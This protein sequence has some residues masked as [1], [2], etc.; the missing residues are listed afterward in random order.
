[1]NQ[2]RIRHAEPEDYQSV[3]NVVD[4]WWGG[5]QMY[6]MLPRLFFTHFRPTSFVAESNGR[7]VTFLIGFLSQTFPEEAYIRF[8]GVHPDCRKDGL[9]RSLYE[10]FFEAASQHN[11]RVVRCVTSPVN[12]S[13][14]AFHLRMGFTP[15]HSDKLID[16]IPVCAGYDGA[17]E[18]RV[19][20][21]KVLMTAS[22]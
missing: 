1:M 16:G 9:G 12:K 8:V 13:S 6:L 2:V 19:V 10:R 4:E 18:D 5:R 20:F 7:M 22:D 11:C 15:K 3:I 14:I 17:G 21:S